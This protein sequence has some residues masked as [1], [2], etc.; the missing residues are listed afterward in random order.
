[1]AVRS[2]M[3]LND[4]RDAGERADEIEH[5]VLVAAGYTGHVGRASGE[6]VKGMHDAL[7]PARGARR[8]EDHRRTAA[9]GLGTVTGGMGGAGPGQG[10]DR[11]HPL[12]RRHAVQDSL[13][14]APGGEEH[15]AISE[16]VDRSTHVGRAA[17]PVEHG[18]GRTHPEQ[19]VIGDDAV[20]RVAAHQDHRGTVLHGGGSQPFLCGGDRLR[21]TKPGEP[22]AI[23]DDRC[24]VRSSGRRRLNALGQGAPSPP[25]G[26]VVRS[27]AVGRHG[28]CGTQGHRIRPPPAWC[29][30]GCRRQD[31]CKPPWPIFL[32]RRRRCKQRRFERTPPPVIMRP[33]R[34]VGLEHAMGDG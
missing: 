26:S 33:L 30:A 22:S 31:P 16:G 4:P 15:P 24:R 11:Q 17:A 21:E 25:A 14:L 2:Q 29:P 7:G 18:H 1:M 27:R 9:V 13:R 34:P 20:D 28:L 3:H 12:R 19:G 8:E 6:S 10:L 32:C 5:A 23:V